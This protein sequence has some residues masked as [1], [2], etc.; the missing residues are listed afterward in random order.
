MDKWTEEQV[1][2]MTVRLCF[3]FKVGGNDRAKLFFKNEFQL[4]SSSIKE[5]YNS[6]NAKTYRDIIYTEAQKLLGKQVGSGNDASSTCNISQTAST[7]NTLTIPTIS[8]LAQQKDLFHSDLQNESST[9][10]LKNI[11]D[12][13]ASKLASSN[14][15][16]SQNSPF[17]CHNNNDN[18]KNESFKRTTCLILIILDTSQTDPLQNAFSS[19]S[20]GFASMAESFGDASKSI[21]SSADRLRQKITSSVIDPDSEFRQGLREYLYNSKSSSSIKVEKN[22][23]LYSSL[24]KDDYELP[25]QKDQGNQT[26][27]VK[28]TPKFT[29]PSNDW[30][31][32]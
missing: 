12:L 1:A 2:K 29:N 28:K 19:V 11:S 9:Y 24:K 16:T 7:T 6:E 4:P 3:N 26:S 23:D 5:R 22:H 21:F 13:N 32:W 17:E 15:F 10:H 31:S 30:D 25:I 27:F 20:D 18:Y 8:T 14:D